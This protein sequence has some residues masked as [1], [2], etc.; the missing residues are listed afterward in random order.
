MAWRIGMVIGMAETRKVTVTLPVTT[1]EA[2]RVLVDA[3][4]ARSVSA[5]VTHAVD[6]ALNDVAGWGAALSEALSSTGGELTAH[7]RAWADEVLDHHPR[8]SG[9][10]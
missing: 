1:F 7:E 9:A 2:V 4:Q 6:V 10:A 5:F 8:R 3:G